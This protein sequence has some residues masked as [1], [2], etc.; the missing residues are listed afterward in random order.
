MWMAHC[1]ILIEISHCDTL[2]SNFLQCSCLSP[3]RSHRRSWVR[4][5]SNPKKV[6]HF[7]L[8]NLLIFF[9]YIYHVHNSYRVFHQKLWDSVHF[10]C[11]QTVVPC[12]KSKY[13]RPPKSQKLHALP[14]LHISTKIEAK[15]R[16]VQADF[17]AFYLHFK[18]GS[19]KTHSKRNFC[20]FFSSQ[21]F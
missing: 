9:V 18:I 17:Y 5:P 2:C 19:K 6:K 4:I 8:F 13:P 16:Q 20:L 7:F 15:Q 12:P 1:T 11:F 10:Q 21:I 3:K 14:S